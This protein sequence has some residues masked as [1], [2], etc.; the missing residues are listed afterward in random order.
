M[1]SIRR[2]YRPCHAI[3]QV[4]CIAV[5][6]LSGK[7]GIVSPL[8]LQ[9]SVT[10]ANIGILGHQE[11]IPIRIDLGLRSIRGADRAGGRCTC[12]AA[13]STAVLA[14]ERLRAKVD[15]YGDRRQEP[16]PVRGSLGAGLCPQAFCRIDRR[17]PHRRVAFSTRLRNRLQ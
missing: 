4:T 15:P 5:N 16:I 9:T 2:Q 3:A 13:T 7:R 8:V 6:G 17:R 11:P 1:P 12:H 14:P 10:A